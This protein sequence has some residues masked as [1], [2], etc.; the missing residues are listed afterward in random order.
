M[1]PGFTTRAVTFAVSVL[2]DRKRRRP[3]RDSF[4][5]I[6]RC[7]PAVTFPNCFDPSPRSA[8]GRFP[9]L[10]FFVVLRESFPRHANSFT[11]ASFRAAIPLRPTFAVPV[12][13]IPTAALGIVT[14][15]VLLSLRAPVQYGEWP[16]NTPN[17]PT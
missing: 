8:R 12:T 6:V 14:V 10:N 3:V 2:R 15:T 13:T 4:S 11:H 9:I 1:P 5:L 7:F 17:R 16:P